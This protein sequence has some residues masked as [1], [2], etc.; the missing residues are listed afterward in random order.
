MFDLEKN[1]NTRKEEEEPIKD[2]YQK[3]VVVK[4]E[5]RV[6]PKR[7]GYSKAEVKEESHK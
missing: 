5:R 6:R 7:F 4:E 1:K 2:V 3:E